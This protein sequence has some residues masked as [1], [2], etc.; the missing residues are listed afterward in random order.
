MSELTLFKSRAA[1]MGYAFKSGKT[2][3]FMG[4]NYATSAKDEIEELTKEC[5]NG[6]P[7]FYI[8]E[9][10]KTID[11]EMMDPM[12][13]LRAKIR[14][15]ERAKLMAATGDPMRD[16]GST[17]QGKLEGI[18]NSH[19]INGMAA[20]S[21]AQAQAAQTAIPAG[22]IKVGAAATPTISVKK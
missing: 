7:N 18:A 13:V 3:H 21:E 20:A 11:S 8:D 14:E 6:H 9:N 10:Q 16:M 19:S 1:T 5:E 12:A 22:T 17:A 15:E 4:G 2:V